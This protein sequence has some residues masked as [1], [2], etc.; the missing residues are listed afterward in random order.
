MACEDEVHARLVQYKV[1]APHWQVDYSPFTEADFLSLPEQYWTLLVS[2]CEKHLP[3]LLSLIEPFRFIPDWRIDDLMISYATDH[4]SVGPH[5]DQYDVFLLQLEGKREWQ[6]ENQVRHKPDCFDNLELAVLREFNPDNRWSVQPGDLLYLPPGIPHHGIAQ[7]PCLTASIGFRAPSRSE[8]IQDF[9]DFMATKF[10]PDERYQDQDLELQA[11]PAEITPVTVEKFKRMIEDCLSI[12]EGLFTE[13][14]GK[15]LTA[16]KTGSISVTHTPGID[17]A[18]HYQ[19]DP[20]ARLA[21]IRWNDHIR[22]FV[23]GTMYKLDS[24]LLDNISR[25]C[26]KRTF[27]IQ[28]FSHP[29]NAQWHALL[30]DLFTMQVIIPYDR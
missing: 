20:Q 10:S 11:S 25:L 18:G 24:S 9:A 4:G 27:R 14:L 1:E 22:F 30:E 17:D 23:N 28:D 8:T 3:Q 26:R 29:D 7:G 16:T 5:V 2:V 21:F 19:R 12:D 13:W 6:I 15:M